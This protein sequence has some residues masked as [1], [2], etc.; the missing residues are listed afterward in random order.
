MAV[1]HPFFHMFYI[2]GIVFQKTG[3]AS[4]PFFSRETIRYEYYDRL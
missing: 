2:L 1:S 4:L 3:A